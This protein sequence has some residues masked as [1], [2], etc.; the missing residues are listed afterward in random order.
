M[1]SESNQTMPEGWKMDLAIGFSIYDHFSWAL[2]TLQGKLSWNEPETL[3][4]YI[5][6]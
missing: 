2:G 4:P 6:V 3:I 5:S 1:A